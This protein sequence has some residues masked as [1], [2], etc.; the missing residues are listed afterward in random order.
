M[1]V[2]ES[3]CISLN[4]DSAVEFFGVQPSSSSTPDVRAAKPNYS[5]SC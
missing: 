1:A 5:L 3:D 4:M 2:G